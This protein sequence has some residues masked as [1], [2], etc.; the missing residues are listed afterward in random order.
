MELI[1]T[2]QYNITAANVLNQRLHCF[3]IMLQAMSLALSRVHC[4]LMLR[5]ILYCKYHI[6]IYVSS[7][8][9]IKD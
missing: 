9:S 2:A 6:S 3:A 4:L 8:V 7:K 5:R 1:R